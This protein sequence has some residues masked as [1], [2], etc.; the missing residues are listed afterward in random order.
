MIPVLRVPLGLLGT[1]AIEAARF[2]RLDAD[3]SLL[4]RLEPLR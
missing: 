4:A 3:A 2:P 1:P